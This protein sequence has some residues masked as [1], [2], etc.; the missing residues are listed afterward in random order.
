MVFDLKTKF[1]SLKTN[2]ITVIEL[3]AIVIQHGIEGYYKLRKAELEALPEINEQV[4]IPGL[5]IPRN[6]TRS[7]NTRAILDQPIL[8]NNALVLKPTRKFIAKS[9]QK[10][11]VCWNWL[12]DYIPSKSK[13]VEEALESLK[14][15]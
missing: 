6:T 8:D 11:K 12:L 3:K 7:V 4:L 13:A 14:S 9:K 15:N 2:H 5:E 10:I 1:S